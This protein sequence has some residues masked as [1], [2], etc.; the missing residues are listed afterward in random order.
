[1]IISDRCLFK[2]AHAVEHEKLNRVGENSRVAHDSTGLMLIS[3]G[4]AQKKT[5]FE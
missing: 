3:T 5:H 2:I 1:M 4:F